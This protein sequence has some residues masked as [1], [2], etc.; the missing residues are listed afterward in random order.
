MSTP[1]DQIRLNLPP[2]GF[3]LHRVLNIFVAL[4]GFIT[5]STFA[6]VSALGFQLNWDA[7]SI[8]QTS[9]IELQTRFG[10]DADVYVNGM[11][12]EGGLPLRATGVFPGNYTLEVKKD[13][14]Q[15]WSRN[16]TVG[17]N[18][19]ALYQ[20]ILLVYKNPQPV[21]VPVVT[22]DDFNM[23]KADTTGISVRG[24]E[25][26]I[27]NEFVT[28]LSEDIVN[29]QWFP[30]RYQLI[31]QIGNKLVLAD[32]DGS[33]IQ[34]LVSA[35]DSTAIPYTLKDSGRILVYQEKGTSKAVALFEKLNFI[36]RLA[37]PRY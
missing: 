10:V 21:D 16:V 36:D 26:W 37:V 29:A 18:L 13:G 11:K 32:L 31:F 33:N 8:Q 2:S 23:S 6:L 9:L 24:N 12:Q 27:G 22:P 19:R 35:A 17:A 30:G 4:T 7:H 14:Y 25:L 34:T 3:P 20:N 15:T 28:R 1:L 5:I